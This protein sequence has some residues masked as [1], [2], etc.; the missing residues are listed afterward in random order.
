MSLMGTLAKV[1][2]G[3]AV[4]KG[5]SSMMNGA[6]GTTKASTGTDGLFGGAHSPQASQQGGGLEDMLG[7]LLGGG[8]GQ[9]GGLGGLQDGFQAKRVIKDWIG[10]YNSERPHTALD[11]RSPD[12]AFFDLERTQ[13]AA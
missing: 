11:K 3:I 8:G 2:I 13:K 10:F 7:G 9:S 12:D 5:A 4:A 6:K 1:A